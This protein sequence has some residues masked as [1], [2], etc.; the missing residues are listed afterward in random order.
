MNRELVSEQIQDMTEEEFKEYLNDEFSRQA[1]NS[2]LFLAIA[3][4]QFGRSRE[5]VLQFLEEEK[6]STRKL[7]KLEKHFTN[8][9]LADGKAVITEDRTKRKTSQFN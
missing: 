6:K 2:P 4:A 8:K 9:D 5:E 1:S 7:L 3:A